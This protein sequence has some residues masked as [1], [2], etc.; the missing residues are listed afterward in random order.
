[1]RAGVVGAIFAAFRGLAGGFP[2]LACVAVSSSALAAGTAP[3]TNDGLQHVRFGGDQH[4]TRVVIELGGPSK[5]QVI[6]DGAAD[7][8]MILGL[9]K[10]SVNDANQGPGQG[11]VKA[12]VAE[13]APGG[14]R[15]KL[16]L[17]RQASI[18]RRFLLP[19]SDGV[20]VYRYVIDL[21][22]DDAAPT[23]Q[24]APPRPVT[25][26]PATKTPATRG[27]DVR[28]ARL[29]A[30]LAPAKAPAITKIS[31]IK[32][33]HLKKVIVIDAGHGGKDPGAA[34][35]DSRE[36]DI[37]LAAAR[38]LKARLERSGRY[39]VVMTRDSDNFVPLENRVQIARAADADLFISLHSDSGPSADM[40]GATVYTLSDKGS[41]RVVRNVM[42]TNDWFI[43]VNLPG[44]DRAVNQILLD[45]TQRAT[46]NRSAAFAEDL[47]NH[48]G[49][50]VPLLQH[51]HRD[52][53]FVV[54]LA[55]DVPAVLLEMGFITNSE[56]EERLNSPGQR[57]RFMN[58]VGDSIDD[59][60]ARQTRIASR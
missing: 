22:A 25:G 27:D 47:L 32:A 46:R 11:L 24:L 45:L 29:A 49:E 9:S 43:N 7:R 15:L 13:D 12:W 44:K 58:A 26:P 28:V 41:D 56:D 38:A 18:K 6:A 1:M 35:A 20:G 14:A 21:S 34:G 19:P 36:K 53:G 40:R 50:R 37:N 52:A 55:P 23:P 31:A 51:S 30:P 10:V 59:Y 42:D 4:E 39:R 48:V 60:F 5:G 3:V 17:N 57:Q 16:Q 2:V 8:L 33:L 54:L